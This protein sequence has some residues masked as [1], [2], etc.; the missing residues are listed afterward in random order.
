MLA[1]W[2]KFLCAE[3]SKRIPKTAPQQAKLLYSSIS[4]ILHPN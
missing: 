2:R 1:I 3:F 4:I